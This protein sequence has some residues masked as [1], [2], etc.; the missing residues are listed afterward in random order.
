MS[1]TGVKLTHLFVQYACSQPFLFCL[2]EQLTLI[3]IVVAVAVVAL[4]V[5]VIV[6][7]YSVFCSEIM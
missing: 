4:S 5:A 1:H 3:V 6:G 2:L 7:K